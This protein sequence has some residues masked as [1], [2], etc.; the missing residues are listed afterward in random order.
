MNT[1]LFMCSGLLIGLMLSVGC[2]YDAPTSLWNPDEEG[3][4]PSAV[5][6]EIVPPNEAA[7]GVNEIEIRGS[8]FA[9][10]LEDNVVYFGNVQA[11]L[12]SAASDKLVL[13]RPNL[14]AENIAVKV[15]V[16]GALTIAKVTSY[17]V[18]SILENYT[19]KFAD[20]FN[21]RAFAIDRDGNY[22][23]IMSNK[24]LRRRLSGSNKE[25]EIAEVSQRSIGRMRFGPD[26]DLYYIRSNNTNMYKFSLDSLT[27][28]E[29][30]VF[31]GNVNVFDFDEKGIAYAGGSGQ[32][33]YAMKSPD[34]ISLADDYTQFNCLAVRVFQ[35]AV[36]VL[37][38]SL[39]NDALPIYAIWKNT[40]N[41]DGTVS[42]KELFLDWSATEYG[43]A[44]A[45]PA[46]IEF[47]SDGTLLI[48]SDFEQPIII[49]NNGWMRPLYKDMLT[50]PVTQLDWGPGNY[51]YF[52]SNVST[53]TDKNVFKTDMGQP[54]APHYGR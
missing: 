24:A 15:L 39:G 46:D 45:V 42:G 33:L 38:E 26:G 12:I 20:T 50:G 19:E 40:I 51:L 47:A 53:V 27:D 54:G 3:T 1:K 37:A 16:P 28:V 43:E 30:A 10:N 21:L 14:V 2:E 44:G 13:Y 5:I 8:N 22:Y 52:F 6:D 34:N 23:V 7:G 41:E 25:E 36:Y 35:G 49:L 11:E 9:S 17:T 4:A 18:T 31:P 32:G 48:S 29:Y